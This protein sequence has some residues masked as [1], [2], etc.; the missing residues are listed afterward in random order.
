MACSCG[1][2]HESSYSSGLF[3]WSG[4]EPVGELGSASAFCRFR[5]ATFKVAHFLLRY[6][7][8]PVTSANQKTMMPKNVASAMET[9]V[10]PTSWFLCENLTSYVASSIPILAWAYYKI[11]AYEVEPIL[12]LIT[13]NVPARTTADSIVLD[14]NIVFHSTLGRG[15]ENSVNTFTPIPNSRNLQFVTRRI[16]VFPDV[17]PS[18]L[19]TIPWTIHEESQQLLWTIKQ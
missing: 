14:S 15:S 10:Y 5:I 7:M 17:L 12:I 3:S 1:V 11:D 16:L 19:I 13:S 2:W 4:R 9:E 18:E 8:M 6:W